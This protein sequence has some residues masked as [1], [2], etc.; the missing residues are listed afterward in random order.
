MHASPY[1]TTTDPAAKDSHDLPPVPYPMHAALLRLAALAPQLGSG[2]GRR[3]AVAARR[4]VM[5]AVAAATA[6]G[7]TQKQ[8]CAAA[9]I[10]DHT[11][12]LWRRQ[13]ARG[14]NFDHREC[15]RGPRPHAGLGAEIRA[16][17]RAALLEK[18]FARRSVREI[19][20]TLRD[21]G[22]YLGSISTLRRELRRMDAERQAKEQMQRELDS[23]GA[24]ASCRTARF[25][26]ALAPNM[27]WS[28]D[29]TL[30]KLRDGSRCRLCVVMDVYDRCVLAW[31]VQACL[32]D[33]EADVAAAAAM[34]AAVLRAALK[35]ILGRRLAST[36]LQLRTDCSRAWQHPA[37]IAA[38]QGTRI[39]HSFSRHLNPRDNTHSERL[40]R[41]LLEWCGYPARGCNSVQ[42]ARRWV[43][44]ALHSYNTEHHHSALMDLTPLQYRRGEQ[45]RIFA[46]HRKAMAAILEGTPLARHLRT[47]QDDCSRRPRPARLRICRETTE[48]FSRR[49]RE[50]QQ[51]NAER[52]A[53]RR[54]RK[55]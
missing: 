4:Q 29:F 36:L 40:W 20:L 25:T 46:R 41:T 11:L 8:A 52:A 34:A 35:K 3:I 14:Q 1:R 54:R 9:G 33:K 48:S 17:R 12:R 39:A 10:S 2:R 38:L 51:W 21:E 53:S 44:R 47:E 6:C 5:E 32:P 50:R 19:G 43:R 37:F 13:E 16:Q 26:Y 28:M 15:N 49:T 27:L 31:Q 23:A 18:R 30:L 55:R 24:T 7:V 42:A 22:R 45:H